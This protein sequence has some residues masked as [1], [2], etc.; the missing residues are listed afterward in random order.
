MHLK[1]PT[2]L[3]DPSKCRD[4]ILSMNEKVKK[5]NLIFRPHFK[6]HQSKAIGKWFAEEGVDKITVSSV[7]MAQYF[8]NDGWNNILIAFPF[9]IKEIDEINALAGKIKLLLTVENLEGVKFLKENLKH[10]VGLYL[11]IDAGYKRTGIKWNNTEKIK[12]LLEETESSE[13]LITEGMLIHSGHTYKADS[14]QKIL[15]IHHESIERLKYIKSQL[16]GKWSHLKLSIGDTPG[17]TLAENFEGVD[18]IRPGNFIFYDLQQ[19]KSGVCSTENIAVCMACPIVSKHE[20]RGEIII[21]GGAVHFSKEYIT[22]GEQPVY[23]YGV[24][25]SDEGWIPRTSG[26]LLTKLSQEHGTVSA[27]PDVFS[28]YEIGDFI[29]FLP[30]HSCLT[31]NLM[32]KYSDFNNNIYDHLSGNL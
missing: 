19:Y 32:K 22:E 20:D 26:M 12:S 5:K 25:I 17:V 4:N 31:A 18:E 27:T 13:H 30:V 6:T 1:K 28:E 8:A 21:Y 10:P 15:Q 11:K 9:N 24:R 7:E 2:L 3:L 16:D 29:G 14:T 23:G